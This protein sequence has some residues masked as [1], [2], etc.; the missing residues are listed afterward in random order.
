MAR[1]FRAVR[2]HSPFPPLSVFSYLVACF[3][4]ELPGPTTMGR[5]DRNS[6][7][8]QS[9]SNNALLEVIAQLKLQNQELVRLLA[10]EQSARD[11]G[12][13]SDCLK[14]ETKPF[15][16]VDPATVNAAWNIVKN[17]KELVRDPC[18]KVIVQDSSWQIKKIKKELERDPSVREVVQDGRSAPVIQSFEE[19]RLVGSCVCLVSR[20][21]AEE[22]ILELRSEKRL[23]FLTTRNIFG[24]WRSNSKSRLPRDSQ[25]CG[26]DT[27]FNYKCSAPQGGHVEADTARVVVA[28]SKHHCH[29]DAWKTATTRPKSAI[30][31]CLRKFGVEPIDFLPPRSGEREVVEVIARVQMDCLEKVRRGVFS[32]PFYVRG[33]SRVYK[34]V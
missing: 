28:F 1:L 16:V 3:A 14:T 22:A 11:P 8:S 23:A 27:W 19:F 2:P 20:S 30:A 4:A 15:D 9:L 24:R 31:H 25:Q 5:K 21:E 10:T 6:Q 7:N 29:P 13:T 12:M 26:R 18:T 32:R 33:E 34:D 17:E